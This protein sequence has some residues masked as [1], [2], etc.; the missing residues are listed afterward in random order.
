MTPAWSWL[1]VA[2]VVAGITTLFYTVVFWIDW[3]L[4]LEWRRHYLRP[5]PK[6]ARPYDQEADL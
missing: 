5:P 4:D 2:L 3:L 6:T 1:L